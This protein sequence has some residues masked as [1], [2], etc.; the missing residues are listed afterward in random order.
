GLYP[1][2]SHI[3]TMSAETTT[4]P[5]LT[6]SGLDLRDDPTPL[7]AKTAGGLLDAYPGYLLKVVPYNLGGEADISKCATVSV[8]MPKRT[9]Y[10]NEPG[11]DTTADLGEMARHSAAAVLDSGTADPARLELS[12]TDLSIAS[13]GPAAALS[14]TYRSDVTTSTAFAPGWRFSFESR[15]TTDATGAVWTDTEGRTMRF[16]RRPDGTYRAPR[17]VTATLT[18]NIGT[19]GEWLLSLKGG[20]EIRFLTDG[21]IRSERDRNG[22][23]VTYDWVDPNALTITAANGQAIAVTLAGGKTVSAQYLGREIRYSTTEDSG[24]VSYYPGSNEAITLLYAYDAAKRLTG[25]SVPEFDPV[26]GVGAEWSFTY[27]GPDAALDECRYPG[28]GSDSHRKA[29]VAYP[30]GSG[31]TLSRWGTVGTTANTQIDTAYTWHPDGALATR[32][33]PGTTTAIT[34]TERNVV[35][36]Q[37]M[38]KT[39][40]G[41]TTWELTDIRG[42][43][44]ASID[45][46]G[47]TST[48][49]YDANDDAVSETDVRGAVT[50]RAYAAGKLVTEEKTLD[51]S[52][53]RS[54]TEYEYNDPSGAMTLQRS[55]IDTDTWA[56]TEFSGF[57]L[58]GE[59]TVTTERGVRL[60]SGGSTYDLTTTRVYDPFGTLTRETNPLGTRVTSATVDIAGRVT[61]SEDASGVVTHTRYDV[62]GSAV[63][64]WRSHESTTTKVDWRTLAIDGASRTL[65][66]TRLGE[67]GITVSTLTRTFDASDRELTSDDSAVPGVSV[68]HYDSAGNA[69]KVWTEGANT[70]LPESSQ[71]STVNAEGQETARLDPGAETS[72][73]VSVYN[74]DGTVDSEARPDGSSST[75]DYDEAGDVAAEAVPTDTGVA[76]TSYDTDLS[77]QTVSTTDPDG[78]TV[79]STYDLAGRLVSTS[80][81][82]VVSSSVVYNTLGWVL[83][84]SDQDG[85]ARTKT[86]DKAGRVTLDTV[87]PITT[88]HAFDACGREVSRTNSA[89]G[90]AVS[91]TSDVF[92]RP[93]LEVQTGTNGASARR[94]TTVWDASGRV[95]STLESVSGLQ[96]AYTYAPD[97]STTIVETR[98][99]G[100]TVTSV[101]DGTGL[102]RSVNAS[103]AGVSADWSVTE[104]DTAGRVTNAQSSTFTNDWRLAYDEAGRPVRAARANGGMVEVTSVPPSSPDPYNAGTYSYSPT[105]GRKTQDAFG[106]KYASRN[107]TTTYTYDISSRLSG[108]VRNGAATTWAYDATSGSLSAYRRP[109]ESTTTLSYDASGRLTAAGP[110]RYASDSL[111]RRT[112]A[113]PSTNPS[114]TAYAWSGER[115]TGLTGPGGVSSFVYDASGQRTRSVITS[116]SVTTTTTWTYDGLRLLGLSA[117]R[118]DA[119]TYTLDYL[120][121]ERGVVFAGI[122]ASS[123]TTP[124]PFLMVTTDRGDVRELIDTSGF[125][126]AHHVYDP[127]G[128]PIGTSSAGTSLVG[129]ATAALIASRQPLRYASYTLDEASGLYYCSQRYYDPSVAA[130]I[131]KD[132]ARAD[133]EESAY[134][135]CGGDPVGKSDPSGLFAMR[136][137][138]PAKWWSKSQ[139]SNYLV[140][141]L[142]R[143]AGYAIKQI[144]LRN[145]V[146]RA[147]WFYRS[148]RRGGAWDLKRAV[149]SS[150]RGKLSAWLLGTRVSPEQFGNIHY[151][152]VGRAS[153]IALDVLRFGGVYANGGDSYRLPHEVFIDGPAITTGYWALS[154]LGFEIKT[155]SHADR[156]VK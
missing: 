145:P 140:K 155:A 144:V 82:G 56:L 62:L 38:T 135:Y 103:V 96:R 108:A 138:W 113:G 107:E 33:E 134:Q 4:N 83:S 86:Y 63:E 119:T 111:G 92:G 76:T 132:P 43:V 39:P 67:S 51:E 101:V 25:L 106:F 7:Y 50:T 71:R 54:R 10:L 143:N 17:S 70:S 53:R 120:Y 125:A 105:T 12:T 80:I 116:G 91:V 9:R 16:S 44:V 72:A 29:K 75:Y 19:F 24:T 121:D 40:M 23:T 27:V 77:G 11:T 112:W 131:S 57:A 102:L 58:N 154:A 149:V 147:L 1:S 122:Y 137:Q 87:G 18:A 139:S 85:V 81:G 93:T 94:T 26:D 123:E 142:R 45:E 90:S 79:T 124:V 115:L 15:V 98:P 126:F 69:T 13:W 49:L 153:G 60:V 48:T 88:T 5:Y 6:G 34:T 22:Q 61:A 100:R 52:G 35:G 65:R 151:G 28:W 114:E 150:Q 2:D 84:Q 64:S 97:G 141:V 21:R 59:P 130:F 3:E 156:W 47:R 30:S 118:S 37:L 46:A 109:G 99:G 42:N 110:R 41:T 66:E 14:R 74:P 32:S 146:D 152:Y 36:A 95:A 117:A 89:D 55:R 31:A 20:D 133:G 73:T 78:S 127:Y 136:F 129:S 148:V 8:Q 128:V 68:T 104:T